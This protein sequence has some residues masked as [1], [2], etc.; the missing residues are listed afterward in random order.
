MGNIIKYIENIMQDGDGN[1]SSKRWITAFFSLLLG[2]GF[3]VSMIGGYKVDPELLH[4]LM[5]IIIAGLGITG[6]EKFA[7]SNNS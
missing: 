1:P 2:V 6:A 3:F 5:Y 7:P 4:A